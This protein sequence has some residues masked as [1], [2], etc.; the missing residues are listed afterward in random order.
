MKAFVKFLINLFLLA[1]INLEYMLECPFKKVPKL[2]VLEKISLGNGPGVKMP[3][4]L[5]C[6]CFFVNTSTAIYVAV[7]GRVGVIRYLLS[8]LDDKLQSSDK[9]TGWILTHGTV[10]PPCS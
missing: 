7:A 8:I 4:T 2:F 10:F 9:I 1:P 6:C 3:L 5:D